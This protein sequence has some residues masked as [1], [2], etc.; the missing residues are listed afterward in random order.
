V[1]YRIDPKRVW[2]RRFGINRRGPQDWREPDWRE[3]THL[4]DVVHADDHLRLI[5][6]QQKTEWGWRK[7]WHLLLFDG[8]QFDSVPL[9][10]QDFIVSPA[11]SIGAYTVE[12]DWNDADNSIESIGAG[13]GGSNAAVN[14][15]GQG[16][17]YSKIT[18]LSLIRGAPVAYQI[19]APGAGGPTGA[20]GGD[21]WFNGATLAASSVGAKGGAAAGFSNDNTALGVGTVKYNG[22]YQAGQ[23][24]GGGAAGPNGH[25][26]GGNTSG[27]ADAGFGGVG[28]TNGPAPSA[29]G[30]GTE[31]DASHGCGGGGGWNDTAGVGAAGGLYGGGGGDGS[32][33]DGGDGGQGLIVITY[34]PSAINNEN[35]V[36]AAAG[37]VVFSHAAQLVLAGQRVGVTIGVKMELEG[38]T[39]NL[40]L[41][42]G[43]LRS[44]DGQEWKGLGELGGVSGLEFGALAATQPVT[45]T[46]SGL[47]AK[48]AEDARSDYAQ[49]RGRRV[50]IYALLFDQNMQ[51]I[52]LPYLCMLATI[53]HASLKRSSD[54]FVLEVVAEPIFSTKHM[55]ALN[56]VTDSDQQTRYP[57]DKIFDRA[58]Y[59]H[60]LY[61]NQ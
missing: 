41:G 3:R 36:S 22:G 17:G 13:A 61:W 28:G 38:S 29:G 21:T 54:T 43:A 5:L 52:D 35:A 47:S 60:T 7:R 58:A 46:L 16:G 33:A 39:E 49:M 11:G 19:G 37:D 10:A 23:A 31:W 45:L 24:R 6:L 8:G 26:V 57:G 30:N 40:W 32:S 9:L 18:N 15:A 44:N 1:T 14:Y 42:N 20:A 51:P 27:N 59:P 56:L 25:G 12:P 4:I 2:Q 48:L 50:S 34:T 55:P 53:D